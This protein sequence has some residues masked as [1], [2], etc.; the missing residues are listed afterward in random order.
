MGVGTEGCLRYHFVV[1]NVPMH[2]ADGMEP[3]VYMNLIHAVSPQEIICIYRGYRW[4][5]QQAQH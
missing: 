4:F 3:E 1:E 2:R 5:V